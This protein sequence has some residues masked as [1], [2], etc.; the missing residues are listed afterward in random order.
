MGIYLDN[1]ATSLP[2][3]P[4]VADATHAYLTE[5]GF[6]A[7]RGGH[8]GARAVSAVVLETRRRLATLLGVSDARN[9][10]F[11]SGATLSLNMLAK[12]LLHRGDHVL[13]SSMEHNALMRPLAQ[14]ERQG[15]SITRIP[16]TPDGVM[17]T[18]SI[19]HLI[20]SNTRALFTTHASNVNGV[21][22]PITTLG[23]T[24]HSHG[25]YLMVD[26]A[27]TAGVFD[28]DMQAMHLDAVAF[29]GHKGLL[30]PQG[31]GGLALSERLAA[32]LEPLILGGTG[33]LSEMAEMPPFL[34][35][36]LE[37]GTPNLPGIYGLH[38]ALGYLVETGL[39]TIRQREQALA[40]MLAEG[41][42]ALP[43]IHLPGPKDWTDRAPVVSADFPG[44]DHAEIAAY[45]DEVHG[46]QIR[47]GLHCAPDAHKALGTFP[48]GTVRFSPGHQT[49]EDEIDRT[50]KAVKAAIGA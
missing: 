18:N 14:M 39:E 8:S 20:Q 19:P 32:E 45:L 23:E 40:S 3:A 2:K 41:L 27:Q 28:I 4:G 16:C 29:S 24:A 17:D 31:I 5:A 35:D 13:I 33:S 21:L 25:I 50:I 9:V 12:G 34:P 7:G 47:C 46:I 11:T 48:Q 1:A 49:T 26:A 22:S 37:A 36:K 30:G 10:V 42:S 38:A 44:R 43:S 15:I 6:S